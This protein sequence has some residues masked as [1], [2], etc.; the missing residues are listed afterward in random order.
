[1]TFVLNWL[2]RSTLLARVYKKLLLLLYA[3][4]EI[5]IYIYIYIYIYVYIWHHGAVHRCGSC[6]VT[7]SEVTLSFPDSHWLQRGLSCN[8]NAHTDETPANSKTPRPP[9]VRIDEN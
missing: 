2:L 5:V 1:M 7:Q 3:P 4:V 6:S 9:A 8:S